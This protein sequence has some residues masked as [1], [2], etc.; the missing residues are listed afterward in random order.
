M[1]DEEMKIPNMNRS[2]GKSILASSV[3]MGVLGGARSYYKA[4]IKPADDVA[5]S[6]PIDPPL[7]DPTE[8]TIPT[9]QSNKGIHST[10]SGLTLQPQ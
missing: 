3:L 8:R 9:L 10:A 4:K 7:S 1:G 6:E 5:P 2:I